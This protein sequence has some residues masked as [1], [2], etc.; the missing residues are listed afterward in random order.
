ME[1]QRLNDDRGVVDPWGIHVQGQDPR[2]TF[3][4]FSTDRLSEKLEGQVCFARHPL[5]LHDLC[6]YSAPLV[7]HALFVGEGSRPEICES[8]GAQNKESIVGVRAKLPMGDLG[9]GSDIRW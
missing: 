3:R 2:D 6:Y 8:I 5:F 7:S 1:S 9:F 4:V